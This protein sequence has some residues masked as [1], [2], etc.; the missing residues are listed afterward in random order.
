MCRQA[1]SRG[2]RFGFGLE[3]RTRSV[4]GCSVQPDGGY[5]QLKAPISVLVM[6]GHD[7]RWSDIHTMGPVVVVVVV[8]VAWL[9]RAG[10][11]IC[12]EVGAGRQ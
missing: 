2:R 8:V 5:N 10:A 1:D 11:K 9:W 6:V 3:G 4:G 7:I 12:H